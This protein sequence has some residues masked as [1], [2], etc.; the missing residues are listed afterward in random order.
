M[1]ARAYE[2]FTAE[3]LRRLQNGKGAKR[4]R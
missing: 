3:L 1:G 4:T 2:A